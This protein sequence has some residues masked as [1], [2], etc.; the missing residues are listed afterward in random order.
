MGPDTVPLDGQDGYIATYAEAVAGPNILD[1]AGYTPLSYVPS[2][3]GDYYIEFNPE[4]PDNYIDGVS[5][6]KRTFH[7]FDI[8]VVDMTDTTEIPGRLWANKWDF[9]CMSGSNQFEAEMHIL[10]TDS[11]LTSLDF[12]GIQPFGF[13]ILA[14]RTGTDI[15]GNVASDRQSTA[16]NLNYPEYKLFLQLPD[17]TSGVFEVTK[18]VPRLTTPASIEGCATDGYNVKLTSSHVGI[19]E[20]FIDVDNDGVYNNDDVYFLEYMAQGENLYP[21]DG[22][23]A[24]GTPVPDGS[25]VKI[26]IQYQGGLTHIPLYDCENH[27]NGYTVNLIA[28][29]GGTPEMFWDDSNVGGTTNLT[30]PGCTNAGG[31]HTWG[32]SVGNVNTVNTYFRSTG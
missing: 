28:P 26:I 6:V 12:N 20:F 31:C 7:Y 17:T 5:N 8:T 32:N 14:N 4:D 19:A 24:G 16:G 15:T 9:N 21:W 23:D 11:V 30:Q 25:N 29:S 22:N 1:A 3:P 27:T 10:G 2:I 18:S 13:E